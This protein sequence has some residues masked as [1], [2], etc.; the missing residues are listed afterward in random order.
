MWS[1]ADH[2]NV[3]FRLVFAQFPS[4]NFYNSRLDYVQ[5]AHDIRILIWFITN[6]FINYAIFTI[7][8]VPEFIIGF[9]PIWRVFITTSGNRWDIRNLR[10]ISVDLSTH[11]PMF[12]W[13]I[14]FCFCF[15]VRDCQKTSDVGGSKCGHVGTQIS[16]NFSSFSNLHLEL[17]FCFKIYPFLYLDIFILK[18]TTVVLYWIIW[19]IYQHM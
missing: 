12:G 13:S 14:V 6:T 1:R 18:S 8:K 4:C 15:F 2:P 10:Q 5:F 16:G 7:E 19:N 9:M 11:M 17:M 3:R